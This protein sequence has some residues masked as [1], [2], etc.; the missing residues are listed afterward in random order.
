M[1]VADWG[2][3]MPDA[4]ESVS[5]ALERVRDYVWMSFQLIYV[6]VSLIG[7]LL[8][9]FEFHTPEMRQVFTAAVVLFALSSLGV[10]RMSRK[11][12]TAYVVRASW[13]FLTL[14]LVAL[15]IMVYASGHLG[16]PFYV[17]FLGLVFF[18]A[19][20]I[21]RRSAWKVGLGIGTVY[22]FGHVAHWVTHGAVQENL[23]FMTTKAM[24]IPLAGHFIG[25]WMEQRL[26]REQAFRESRDEVRSLNDELTRR[27]AELHVVTEITEIIHSTLDFDSIGP[28][29]LD[30]LKKAIDMPTCS[31]M[32]VDRSTEATVFS[33]S[34]GMDEGGMETLLPAYPLAENVLDETLEDEVMFTCT[35][36]VEHNDMAAVFCCPSVY[37][38][39]GI[40]NLPTGSTRSPTTTCSSCRP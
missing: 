40:I 32:V 22:L 29:V 34:S 2:R 6:A 5:P 1:P 25:T 38:P 21:Q 9:W 28:L 33:A 13:A 11:S 31:L 7:L 26:E 16:D 17:L 4:P 37:E 20:I 27:L 15:G 39:F 10:W 30:S 19:S 14:D 35:N 24:A 12:H 3:P 23:V 18:Y 8:G 36:I